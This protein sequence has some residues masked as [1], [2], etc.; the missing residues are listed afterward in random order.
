MLLAGTSLVVAFG[1]C[2]RLLDT[3]YLVE[4]MNK[5]LAIPFQEEIPQILDLI[6]WATIFAAMNW[7]SVYMVKFAFL[8]FFYTLIQGLPKRITRLYWATVGISIICW[9]YTVLDP[10]IICP[11]FGADSGKFIQSF[12]LSSRRLMP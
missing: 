4:A 9:I 2:L 10:I 3:L 6:K 8:N 12:W 7:T 11:H 5:G 1:I